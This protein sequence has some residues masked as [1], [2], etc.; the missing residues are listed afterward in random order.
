MMEESLFFNNT[1]QTE[2]EDAMFSSDRYTIKVDIPH[3]NPSEYCPS[4]SEMMNTTKYEELI[5]EINNSSLPDEEKRFLRLAATR[6]I[7]FNYSKVADYYAHSD[8]EMQTLL[9]HSA[10]V[11]VDINNAMANGFMRL[12]KVLQKLAQDAWEERLEREAAEQDG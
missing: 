6:H 11:I 5:N 4:I 10:M 9:E 12:D 8:K 1:E 2:T 3:Y 7:V